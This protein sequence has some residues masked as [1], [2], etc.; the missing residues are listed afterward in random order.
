LQAFVAG[1]LRL[2]APEHLKVEVV[3]ILQMGVRDKPYTVDEGI[4]RVE[5]FE[6]LP[7]A[8]VPNELLFHGAF[9]IASRV[10]MA[11]YDALYLALADA[12]D[13]AFVTADRRLY[14]LAQQRGIARIAWFQ[15][16]A[17]S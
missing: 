8:Y 7:I 15:D 17:P 1:G 14:N 16:F 3:R 6:A 9:R 10:Q 4:A 12:L 5:A 11:L 2:T 13:A